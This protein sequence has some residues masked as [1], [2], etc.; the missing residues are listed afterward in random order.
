M[1]SRRWRER[2]HRGSDVLYDR[3]LLGWKEGARARGRFSGS[4]SRVLQPLTD[5]HCPSGRG[6][7]AHEHCVKEWASHG[8]SRKGNG[9]GAAGDELS[10]YTPVPALPSGQC[11]TVNVNSTSAHGLES[12][13]EPVDNSVISNKL[14]QST[15]LTARPS[16]AALARFLLLVSRRPFPAGAAWRAICD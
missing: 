2:R 15:R 1:M 12:A 10:H 4:W 9:E 6:D 5:E 11:S 8:E 3:Q 13:D 7:H 16:S 14:R